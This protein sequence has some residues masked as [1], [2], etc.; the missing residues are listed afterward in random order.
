MNFIE[1]EL[2]PEQPLSFEHKNICFVYIIRAKLKNYNF[3][4]IGMSWNV[5]L[6]IK[7]LKNK[8]KLQNVNKISIIK[9]ETRYHAKDIE[10]KLLKHFSKSKITGEFFSALPKLNEVLNALV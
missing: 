5:G 4:K 2:K 7:Q 6:R 10:N 3:Y 8:Y 1:I 9:T